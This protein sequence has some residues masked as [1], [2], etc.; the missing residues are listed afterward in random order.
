MRTGQTPR[1][2]DLRT[3]HQVE[4]FGIN[5]VFVPPSK[6]LFDGCTAI[7]D[8]ALSGEDEDDGFGKLGD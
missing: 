8:L 6:E 1:W 4:K 3:I 5:Q 2:A 7:E